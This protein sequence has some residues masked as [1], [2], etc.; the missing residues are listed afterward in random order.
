V[1]TIALEYFFT[2]NISVETICCVTG[3]HVTIGAGAA[4]GQGAIDDV[5]IIPA[6]FTAKYHVQLPYGIKPYAG[7]GPPCS[8]CCPTSP[9]ALPRAWA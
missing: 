2:K 8:S 1:P 9:A 3:H 5:K 7:V 6:T 4:A